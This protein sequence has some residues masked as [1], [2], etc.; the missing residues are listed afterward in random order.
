MRD[1]IENAGYL[2]ICEEKVVDVKKIE[3]LDEASKVIY[4]IP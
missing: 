1:K 3:A 2:I 4:S